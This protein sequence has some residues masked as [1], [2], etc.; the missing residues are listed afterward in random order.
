[1]DGLDEGE[2]GGG[3]ARQTSLLSPDLFVKV[4]TTSFMI[5]LFSMTVAV[6]VRCCAVYRC[7]YL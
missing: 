4:S 7:K 6:Y 1:M 5:A 2:A 3:D